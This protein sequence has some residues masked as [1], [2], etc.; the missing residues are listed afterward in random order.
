MEAQHLATCPS[1]TEHN[2]TRLISA[3]VL[4]VSSFLPAWTISGWVLYRGILIFSVLFIILCMCVPCVWWR[5]TCQS[6]CVV[7]GPL[8]GACSLRPSWCGF[9]RRSWVVRFGGRVLPTEPSQWFSVVFL[10]IYYAYL[11]VHPVRVRNNLWKPRLFF[12]Y[13]NSRDRTRVL[14]IVPRVSAEPS[15]QLPRLTF[16]NSKY[17][18]LI[19]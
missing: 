3:T 5:L 12:Y 7:G 2:V 4:M 13:M 6:T 9:Q 17:V 19:F 15:H 14:R 1:F 11:C 16:L 8:C 18:F 10:N